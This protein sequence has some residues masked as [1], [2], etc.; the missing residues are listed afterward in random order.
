MKESPTDPYTD[1][2]RRCEKTYSISKMHECKSYLCLSTSLNSLLNTISAYSMAF[3]LLLHILHSIGFSQI[4]SPWEKLRPFLAGPLNF[5]FY[6]CS[7][8]ATLIL[9]RNTHFYTNSLSQGGVLTQPSTFPGTYLYNWSVLMQ[10]HLTSFPL[11]PA[12][13]SQHVPCCT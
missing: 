2:T 1:M 4:K 13:K 12:Q 3:L 11:D 6:L 9:I 8:K 10:L 7:C 5:L